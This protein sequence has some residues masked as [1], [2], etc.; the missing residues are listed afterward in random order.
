MATPENSFIRGVHS[1][2]PPGSP[3]HMKNHNAYTGGV[4]DVWYSGSV[5][6]LWVEYKHI[7][8]PVRG[9]TVIDLRAG[10]TPAMTA[11]Q[12]LWGRERYAEGRNVAVIIGCK[13][14][15]VWLPGTTWDTSW[16][17]ALFRAKIVS[18]AE[19]A[20]IIYKATNGREISGKSRGAG[21]Q[22]TGSS[23]SPDTSEQAPKAQRLR[24]YVR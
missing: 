3:Y 12:Q 20:A 9:S 23:D 14:G 15:G 7:T 4:F 8:V 22:R 19:L 5:A 18:R 21:P 1:H 2:L 10:K 16:P 6:D 13:E 11:L 24:R 17:A